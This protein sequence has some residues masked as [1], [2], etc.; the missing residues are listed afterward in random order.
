[1]L[2]RSTG[3]FLSSVVKRGL[4][5]TILMMTMAGIQPLASQ[6]AKLTA[7]G[8]L[9]LSVRSDHP[10]IWMRGEDEWYRNE[11]GTF[12][13]RVLH[14]QELPWP[15]MGNPANDQQKG[16]FSY[17]AG[18][19]EDADYGADNMFN[20]YD[21]DFAIRVLEPIIA[22]KAQKA[23]WRSAYQGQWTLDHS[24]DE[25]FADARAKLLQILQWSPEYEFPYV[26]ALFAAT[27]YDWLF[28]ETFSDGRPVLSD[29][30]KAQI[31]Q[32]LIV[33]ADYMKNRANGSG[34][35]FVA[36]D[37]DEYYYVMMGLALYEPSRSGDPAYQAVQT[38]AQGYLD[39]FEKD[40]VGRVLPFWQ[41]QGED[42]GWHG[43]FNQMQIPYWTG[44]SYETATNVT[45]LTTAPILFAAYTATK[46]PLDSS[47]FNIGMLKYMPEFQLHMIL[48]SPMDGETD[49]TYYDIDGPGD[50][51]SRS[52][53]ILPMRAYSRRRFSTDAEQ[54]RLAELG[55]WIRTH[56]SKS[57][58]DAGS[59]DTTDQLLFEDKWVQ[60][61]A[62][63]EIGFP[64]VRHFK[65]LGRVFMR[66]G[67]TSQNDLAGLFIC[68]PYHWSAMDL[69]AQNALLLYY[70]GA[71]IKGYYSPLLIGN[72]KQRTVSTFPSIQDGVSSYAPG[73]T[74][75]VGPGI[76]VCEDRSDHLYIVAEARNAYS[77]DKLTSI[78]RKIVYLKPNRFILFDQIKTPT[79]DS[80]LTW[81]FN[82]AALFHRGDAGLLRLENSGGGA[83][84]MKRLTPT[85][86]VEESITAQSYEL[87][88]NSGSTE[89][90][91]VHVLQV[92]DASLSSTSPN[93]LIDDAVLETFQDSL[94]ISL[95]DCDV[96]FSTEHSLKV[97]WQP[98]AV[99][100][101]K[102]E[103]ALPQPFQLYQNYPN[104]FNPTTTIGLKMDYSDFV[105]IAI[106]DVDGALHSV[107]FRGRLEPGVYSYRWDGKDH[108][109]GSSPSGV[110]F[111][112]VRSGRHEVENCKMVL[113]H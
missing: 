91:F 22:G 45:P 110:Y 34:Q 31:Q 10:R 86:A 56:F 59:W 27:A 14:G 36:T 73:S 80:R 106:Y 94:R 37:V 64:L 43:G 97:R 66:S 12:A 72:S 13:W 28:T 83:L 48:P 55:A 39:A 50:R 18:A 112:Q 63:Q 46:Q 77:K 4:R 102:A 82:P 53:W 84:W 74:W 5:F 61:R 103:R 101:K 30:D 81:T 108:Q 7:P 41:K 62:P 70:K 33:H 111:C 9:A 47:L 38:K 71:L 69:Y 23:N 40:F 24:A 88:S 68:Q 35:P 3:R 65:S 52:P 11:V 49:A 2:N 93:L 87:H 96:T 16:E 58:T 79:A 25:Y 57:K 100:E 20:R 107:L 95:P 78:L 26:M 17:A 42:G 90:T 76:L 99:P 67:F 8:S 32:R 105:E 15:W 75:D 109:G 104:P 113:L 21:H 1:M 6:T 29:Q 85:D 89:R 60:P 98:A 92:S 19:D 44:G 54:Q 51:Y